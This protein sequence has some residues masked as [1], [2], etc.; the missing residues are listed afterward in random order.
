MVKIIVD[1][2][3]T[4]KILNVKGF[5]FMGKQRRKRENFCLTFNVCHVHHILLIYSSRNTLKSLIK[6]RIIKDKYV[7]SL[8]SLTANAP[9]NE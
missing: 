9:Q 3:N 8:S 1:I 6:K 4:Y 2:S 7:I 5:F